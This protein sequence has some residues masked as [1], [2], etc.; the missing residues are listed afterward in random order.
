MRIRFTLFFIFMGL[1]GVA[2]AQTGIIKGRVYNSINSEAV[3]FANVVIQDTTQGA[4]TD[5]DG[6]YK[7]TDLK[8][9]L[10]NL[11]VSYVGF[12]KKVV[13]EVQV[14]EDRPT[15]VNIPL[16]ESSQDL[17]EV[18]VKG[19]AFTRREE[20]PV[21]LNT[22]GVNEIQRN[23]G[24]NRDISRA[25]QVLPGV[26]NNVA[27][28]NDIIIRGGAPS[29]NAFYLDGVRVPNINHFATQGASGGPVGLINVNFIQNVEFYSGS[30]PADRGGALS[31]I[32]EFQQ[33]DGNPDKLKT[34]FTLGSSDFGL[35][36]DGPVSKKSTFIFSLRRSYL[37][38]LFQAL[39]LPFLPTYNDAQF[40]YKIKFDEKNELSFIGLG[41]YD[42][43][44]LNDKSALDTQDSSL[45][46]RN[47][48]L[49]NNLPVFKQWNY[50]LGA[51]YKH[52]RKNSF[53]TIVLSRNQL[54]NGST[55]Y[56]NNLTND[57]QKLLLDY[58]SQEIENRLR[59]EDTYRKGKW[60]LN[61]GAGVV[62]PLYTNQTFNRISLPD[63]SVQTVNF[64]SRL[65][66][67]RY[68][69]FGQASRS[70]NNDRME[71]SAG[72]RTDFANYSNVTSN[73]LKQLSP[74]LG[75][76]YSITEALRFNASV[77]RYYKLPAYTVLGYR[78]ANGLLVNQANDVTYIRCDQ[79]IAGFSYLFSKSNTRLSLEGFWK[80]YS[81]YPFLLRDSISLANLGADYGVI[82]NEPAASI[83]EGRAYG[84]E[85][86]AQRKF[87]KGIYGILSLTWVRSE[88][89][90]KH[91]VYI[92]SAWDS[93]VIVSLTAGKK[94]SHNWEVNARA[95]FQGGAPYTPYDYYT[96]SLRNVWDV[97]QQGV[98]NYNK[99]N[100]LRLPSF[101]FI[102]AR[103]DKKYYFKKW[104]LD[105]YLDVQNL[106]GAVSKGQPYLD[107]VRDANGNPVVNPTD[108]TRY[109]LNQINNTSGN[110]L[111]SIGIVAEF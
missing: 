1:L 26:A 8:P 36:F 76:S 98:L 81:Q 32:L 108:N 66:F 40:K 61:G 18:E 34:N 23:P 78:D 93:R 60:K 15:V 33:K 70:F 110:P 47:Q 31:S 10:Y 107:V 85:F 25:I 106:T 48:Y 41:A 84:A 54:W 43:F 2:E 91:G 99:L 68:S 86:L 101:Y 69:I 45:Y 111:P 44:K 30:F 42:N 109:L 22:I 72:L 83:G 95:A 14:V 50:T 19:K 59:F 6:N 52:F 88:F 89:K 63:G 49:L 56:Q 20:A 7:I 87:Y 67:E 16:K 46:M 100:S 105:V 35:T 57:P 24:G 97:N 55:K 62:V 82:G 12:E 73:P 102:D 103:V 3:P 90:D 5:I 75:F 13:Y 79:G 38:F 29:E 58:S 64:G 21:S 9:G 71:V 37:Q 53:Q 77:A 27:F 96:T 51:V 11:E 17:K 92:P 104:N 39:K 28:R 94:F 74:R 4:S 65:S 80:Q